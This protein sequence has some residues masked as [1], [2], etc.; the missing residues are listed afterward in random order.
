MEP[1]WLDW[2]RR[3]QALAHNGAVFAANPFDLE[4]YEAI[5]RIAG[6]ILAA[7]SGQDLAAVDLFAME[8]GYVT[9]KVDVRGVVFRDGALLLVRERADNLWTLPGGWADVGQSPA[10]SVVREV[11]EESGYQAR[12]VKLL[13]VY[14]RNRHSHTPHPFYIYKL[15]F[16]CELLGGAPAASIETSEVGFFP[17]NEIPALSITRTTPGQVARMFEHARHPDWPADYD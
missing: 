7:G 4:R 3:L 15:F 14:D 5:A 9:P 12:A 2:A 10:E 16:R 8:E 17:E 6:E 1:Q 11:Y 13:A